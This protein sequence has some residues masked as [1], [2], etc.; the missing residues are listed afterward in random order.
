MSNQD[1]SQQSEAWNGVMGNSWASFQDALDEMMSP[2][3][4]KLI[5]VAKIKP[6]ERVLDIGCGCGP[7]TIAIARLVGPKGHVTGVD[8]SGLL[9]KSARERSSKLG[10]SIDFIEADASTHRFTSTY[11]RLFSRFGVMFFADPSEAFKNLRAALKPGGQMIFAC[12]R[13][14]NENPFMSELATEAAKIVPMPAPPPM[15][16]YVPGPAGF[17]DR[18]FTQSM[19][20][21][22]GFKDISIN[23]INLALAMPGKTLEERIGFYTRIGPC[24]SLMRDASEAQRTALEGL[25]RDWV[26]ERMSAGR[27][28]QEGAIWLVQGKS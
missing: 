11:D 22:A 14:M 24:A 6:G 16:G 26:K 7:T 27:N 25:T 15:S 28:T 20:E 13:A 17:A 4:A 1:N 21:G 5:E 8:I 12:W 3:T 18:V 9:L 10:L 2:V 23:P 19:L